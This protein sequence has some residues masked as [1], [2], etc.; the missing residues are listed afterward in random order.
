VGGFIMAALERIPVVG[1]T[2]DLDDG[3]LAVQRMDGRRV[4]RVQFT[5]TPREQNVDDLVRA[6]KGGDQ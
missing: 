6:A 1:D 2:V 4:D 3:I 5:P